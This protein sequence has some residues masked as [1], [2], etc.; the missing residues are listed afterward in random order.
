MAG[1]IGI[2]GRARVGKDTAGAWLVENRGYERVGF[3]DAVR[4]AAL[5]L[6][7][8]VEVWAYSDG[9]DVSLSSLSEYVRLYG[10]ERAKDELPE[11]RRILQEFGMAIRAID[12]D[13]WLRAALAKVNEIN[14]SGRSA[15]ITDVRFPNEAESL[16]R[17][18]F[19]LLYID[20]P[21]VEVIDHPSEGALTAE[22]AD[23]VIPNT[24]DVPTFLR[25]VECT[26]DL[27]NVPQR[28]ALGSN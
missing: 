9:T 27:L 23:Y 10:W 26:A 17:A 11:V 13:F 2:I 24:T 5:R 12:E 18:G 15:V 14:E 4:Y 8:I 19:H 7:P 16:K 25:F 3:A 28:Y 21:G 22:D 1:N 20:R 6:D